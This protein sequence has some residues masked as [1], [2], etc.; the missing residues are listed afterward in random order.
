M[1]EAN[2]SNL[3]ISKR[4]AINTLF[5]H[6]IFLEQ[7]GKQEMIDAILRTARAS[8]SDP[9]N[10]GKFMWHHVT[11]YTSRLFESRSPTSLNRVIAL[12]SPFVSWDDILHNPIAVSRWAA[13]ALAIPYTDQIGQNVIDALFQITNIDLLRPHV[14]IELWRWLKKRP[15]MPPVYSGLNRAGFAQT[16]AHVRRLSDGDIDILKSYF[17]L[18][19]AGQDSYRFGNFHEMER[20]VREDFGGAGM[21][22][23]RKDLVQQLDHVLGQLEGKGESQNVKDAKAQYTALKDILL[24]GQKQ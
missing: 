3:I 12:I 18:V 8:D 11:L 5:P 24:E 10:F 16:T 7:S 19:W 22:H 1:V 6:A 4:K 20:S 13:A 14:P 17:L 15:V 2:D 21:E 23:H 9:S